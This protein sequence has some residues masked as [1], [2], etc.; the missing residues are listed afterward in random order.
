MSDVSINIDDMSFPE[1][2]AYYKEE[3]KKLQDTISTFE[4]E[5]R[6][7]CGDLFECACQ[8]AIARMNKELAPE[9]AGND[10]AVSAGFSFFEVLSVSICH[11]GYSAG[12]IN[13]HLPNYISDI[14]EDECD[15]FS[16]SDLLVIEYGECIYRDD[17]RSH[18][19][20]LNRM[21]DTF[22]GML[23]DIYNSDKVQQF[24]QSI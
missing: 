21:T 3:N 4:R 9:L 16:S 24:C 6:D 17:Y 1:Q 11:F 18:M 15:N 8:R 5:C 13:P 2:L 22:Y 7:A 14:L 20:L 10:D 12:E 23:E 19:E